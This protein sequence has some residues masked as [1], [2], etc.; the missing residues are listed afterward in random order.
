VPRRCVEAAE[1]KARDGTAE[2]PR[3]ERIRALKVEAAIR[4]TPKF[5]VV[6]LGATGHVHRQRSKS[7]RAGKSC[8]PGPGWV[9]REYGR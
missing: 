9:T 3:A 8:A 1:T 2:R 5:G 6:E 7:P 4:N